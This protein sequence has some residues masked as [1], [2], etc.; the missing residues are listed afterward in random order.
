MPAFES[1]DSE[2]TLT[3]PIDKSSGDDSID[4]MSSPEKKTRCAQSPMPSIAP[5]FLEECFQS[6]Q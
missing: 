5:T 6:I 2:A 1:K 3:M 4:I